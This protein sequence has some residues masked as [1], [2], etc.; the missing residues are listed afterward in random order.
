MEQSVCSSTFFTALQK[1]HERP[2]S[3]FQT[4]PE[5]NWIKG[6]FFCFSSVMAVESIVSP[7]ESAVDQ[8]RPFKDSQT[9][10]SVRKRSSKDWMP[11]EMAF[12]RNRLLIKRTI[13]DKKHCRNNQGDVA[14]MHT[15]PE[16]NGYMQHMENMFGFKLANEEKEVRAIVLFFHYFNWKW[17]TIQK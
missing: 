5:P 11:P 17:F 15:F 13:M 3:T 4:R 2:C 7:V 12:V 14:Q 10:Q 8:H 9:Y 16:V 1:W 6:V